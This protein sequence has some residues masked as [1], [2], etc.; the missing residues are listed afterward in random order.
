MLHTFYLCYQDSAVLT[1]DFPFSI[2]GINY[3]LIKYFI[4]ANFNK[5][6]SKG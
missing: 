1:T 6:T 3:I 4:E 2:S 5:I